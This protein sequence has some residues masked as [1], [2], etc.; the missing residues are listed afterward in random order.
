M[1]TSPSRAELEALNKAL[2]ESAEKVRGDR[3]G[4]I[5]F[6]CSVGITDKYGNLLPPYS[7][8]AVKKG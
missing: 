8:I 5:R 1:A 4:A 6:L 7:G 3:E 2:R